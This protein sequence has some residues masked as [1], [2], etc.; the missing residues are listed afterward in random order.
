MVGSITAIVQHIHLK[1]GLDLALADQA[2]WHYSRF[3]APFSS[4]LHK[5]VLGD[6]FSPIVAVLAPLYW[7]WSDPRMLLIA[8]S[9][10]VAASI[11][12][13][14]LFARS[15]LPRAGAYLVTVAYAAFWG[16]QVGMLY[17]FH[18]LCFAPLLI[19][20]AILF[21]DR[22]RWGWLWVAVVA[23]L[24]TKEDISI[25]V[26]FLGIWLLTMRQPRQ[27]AALIIVGI[28]WYELTTRVWMPDL[29]GGEPYQH[30]TYL[31][32]GKNLPDAFWNLFRHPWRA[33]TVG[34]S[35]SEK[36]GTFVALL[37]P[38]L[39]LSFGSRLFILAIPLLAERLLSTNAAFW[40][41][42][43]QYSLSIAPVLAMA[44]AAGLANI[45]G[46]ITRTPRLR[47]RVAVAATAAMAV[48]SVMLTEVNS[49]SDSA[50]A[51][52]T[53]SSFYA[54][55]PW[56]PGYAEALHHVPGAA[57]V[58]SDDFVLPHL[59]H[60]QSVMLIDPTSEGRA[61]YLITRIQPPLVCCAT[62]NAG[63][64][65][66]AEVT[67]TQ[68]SGMT[69]VYFGR[70]WIVAR[71]SPPGRPPTNGVLD[72]I[73]PTSAR[74]VASL[75]ARLDRLPTRRTSSRLRAALLAIHRQLRGGC[76]TLAG[77]ALDTAQTGVSLKNQVQS[78]LILCAPRGTPGESAVYAM[79]WHAAT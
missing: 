43:Y 50:L 41:N 5:D 78:F 53:H 17:D 33:L 11:V 45:S 64:D 2:V 13:V 23:L 76:G 75:A 68:L 42:Q 34:F 61:E 8:Q 24:A 63:F 52:I 57:S 6:H 38:F 7:I 26:V 30:W 66:R 55:P 49:S 70:G 79:R 9:A 47:D 10:L 59:A 60:R 71:R 44:A 29:V 1:S 37:T 25:L 28:A 4:I 72:A 46:L 39:F 67:N 32:I 54:T 69:P 65:Q 22:R 31:E 35:N 56:A 77:D 21:A 12:P 15:R 27:G 62:G 3:E 20:L 14:F 16:L 73:S 19:A 58:A 18:E 36:L 74:T 40:T 51:V 48:V